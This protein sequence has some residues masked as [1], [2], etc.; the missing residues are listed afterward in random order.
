MTASSAYF[1]VWRPRCISPAGITDWVRTFRGWA[2]PDPWPQRGCCARTVTCPFR[3]NGAAWSPHHPCPETVGPVVVSRGRG[4]MARSWRSQPCAP[5]R[6]PFPRLGCNPISS[7]IS[8]PEVCRC[9]TARPLVRSTQPDTVLD[10]LHRQ[11]SFTPPLARCACHARLR[12]RERRERS[13]RPSH[14]VQRGRPR[15]RGT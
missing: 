15:Q 12:R 4:C 2:A 9:R 3:R 5:P 1:C 14:R 13:G 11:W 10:G 8:T 6:Q 7:P